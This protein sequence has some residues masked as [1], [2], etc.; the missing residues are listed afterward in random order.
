MTS[1]RLAA[2]SWA[3]FP[4]EIL[5]RPAGPC[6]PNPPFPFLCSLLVTPCQPDTRTMET[7]SSTELLQLCRR[8]SGLPFAATP[9]LCKIH[10]MTMTF[11][12]QRAAHRP[13]IPSPSPP[14]RLRPDPPTEAAGPGRQACELV[15]AVMALTQRV[16]VFPRWRSLISS[17][18]PAS[19]ALCVHLLVTPES[20]GAR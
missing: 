7:F 6:L 11:P 17:P 12:L 10:T 15:A 5:S 13:D 20:S 2:G 14:P 8:A 4:K 9:P 3:L 18:P 16:Y 19:T 1:R